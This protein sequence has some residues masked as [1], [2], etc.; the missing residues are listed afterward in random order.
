MSNRIII[1]PQE[2]AAVLL[3]PGMGIMYVLRGTQAVR[4]DQI[5]PAAWFLQEKISDKIEVSLPWSILEPE[6]GKFNWNHPQWE[7]SFKSWIDKGFKV[8]L[9]VRGMAS[10]GTLYDD[11]TPQWVFDAGAKYID[12]TMDNYTLLPMKK[13]RIPVY[14]DPVYLKKAQ[15]FIQAMG[16]RYNGKPWLEFVQI[17]HMGQNGGMTLAGQT[18]TRPWYDAGFSIPVYKDAHKKIIQ[19]YTEAFPNTQLS[20]ALGVPLA[21]ENSISDMEEIISDLVQKKIML[22]FGESGF[23]FY[24]V[25]IST[26]V[27]DYV[28]KYCKAYFPQTKIYMEIFSTPRVMNSALDCHLSYWHREGEGTG[29]GLPYEPTSD[30]AELY[31]FMARNIGYRFF[32][33]EI[34]YPEQI[35]KGEKFIIR[36][37]WLNNGSAPCYRDYGMS[38]AL[39]GPSGKIVWEDIQL[40]QTPT[41][42]L[43]WNSGCRV[44]ETLGWTVRNAPPGS[45]DLRIGLRAMKN[46]SERIELPLAGQDDRRQYT[47]GKIKIIE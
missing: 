31:R 40:P 5:D 10:R 32:L 21:G 4:Y 44:S 35:K 19:S 39:T 45:Y 3:N 2:T 29:L 17:A 28:E 8:A 33:K 15:N 6:E 43:G 38:L 9:K 47:V 14:W 22:K 16:E 1:H 34:E 37:E 30:I 20:Q 7:G 46:D 18:D 26:E 36:Y 13:R 41:S 27:D 11:G 42:S 25:G 24:T 12:E 23:S